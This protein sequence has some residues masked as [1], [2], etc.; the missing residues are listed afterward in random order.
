MMNYKMR[1][2][3]TVSDIEI[4]IIQPK[5]SKSGYKIINEQLS[6]RRYTKSS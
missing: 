3:N 1:F 5:N 4:E 6:Y 2:F